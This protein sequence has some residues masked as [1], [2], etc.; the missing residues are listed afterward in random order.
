MTA[1]SAEEEWRQF[2]E[3]IDEV[4][5]A[6]IEVRDELGRQ[7]IRGVLRIAPPWIWHLVIAH[8]VRRN[9]ADASRVEAGVFGVTLL[10]LWA[11]LT[12]VSYLLIGR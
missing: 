9:R 10:V 2:G 11:A 8:E 5:Q 7:F 4:R 1:E 6:W 12:A 3:A